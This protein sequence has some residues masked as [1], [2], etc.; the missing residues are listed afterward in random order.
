MAIAATATYYV[1]TVIEDSLCMAKCSAVIK[2]PYK[3]NINYIVERQPDSPI[4]V[5][6][7]IVSGIQHLGKDPD[8]YLIFYRTYSDAV[9]VHECLAGHLGL[10][11]TLFIE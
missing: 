1:Q 11:E 3:L 10:S 9:L 4:T 8:K 7:P 2:V 6:L 5:L